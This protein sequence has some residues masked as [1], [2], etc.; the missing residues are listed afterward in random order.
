MKLWFREEINPAGAQ[1]D[2]G[3]GREGVQIQKAENGKIMEVGK[4]A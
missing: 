2:Q 3:E 4:L 1:S